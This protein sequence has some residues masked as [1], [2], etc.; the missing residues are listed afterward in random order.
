M[1]ARAACPMCAEEL[2]APV[3]T[4]PHC[5]SPTGLAVAPAIMAAAPRTASP[6][7]SPRARAPTGLTCPACAEEV[8]SAD[9]T[10]PHCGSAT[11]FGVASA[12][13]SP[14]S[15][16]AR[17]AQRER[18]EPA[19]PSSPSSPTGRRALIAGVGAVVGIAVVAIVILM[20]GS[21]GPSQAPTAAAPSGS[22]AS[23]AAPSPAARATPVAPAAVT[24]TP[25]LEPAQ[26]PVPA[27][28]AA[29][30]HPS[31]TAEVQAFVDAQARALAEGSAAFAATFD[32]SARVFL[33][34]V[35][36]MITGRTAL[37]Q[38]VETTWLAGRK[39]TVTSSPATLIG[40]VVTSTW[41]ATDGATGRAVDVRVTEV[42]APGGAAIRVIA[43]S[44]SIAPTPGV[45]AAP[46]PRELPPVSKPVGAEEWLGRPAE[47]ARRLCDAPETTLIGSDAREVAVGPVAA[48]RL[49]T[50]WGDLTM[51]QLGQPFIVDDDTY[52]VMSLVRSRGARPVVYR[53]LAMFTPCGPE[54]GY[55]ATLV[56]YSVP[57]VETGAGP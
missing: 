8:S 17:A 44:F 34:H 21:R 45:I 52:L 30:P 38:A 10:C 32:A 24:V 36:D 20:A 53:A 5:G 12:A 57:V 25:S 27:A 29:A 35:L 15:P 18:S 47:L 54:G 48:E 46:T 19:T 14:A 4:C 51:D 37:Q 3:A 23:P 42:L 13:P 2:E 11:G 9:R 28:P 16:Q 55:L 49:L 6:P 50:S 1:T 43:A 26:A 33:P 41:R 40:E 39:L 7:A 31:T 56:H 22:A